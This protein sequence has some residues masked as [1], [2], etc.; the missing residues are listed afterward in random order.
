ML[1]NS[2]TW[3]LEPAMWH[4]DIGGKK[5]DRVVAPVVCEASIVQM[6]VVDELL[7]G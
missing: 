5:A 4:S 2:R 1:L 6:F 3:R 7:N